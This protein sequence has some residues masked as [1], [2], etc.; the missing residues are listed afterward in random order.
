MDKGSV[1]RPQ[2]RQAC[3]GMSRLARGRSC[4]SPKMR[5]AYVASYQGPTLLDRRPIIR[6][7]SMSNRIKIELIAGLLHDGSKD[8]EIISQGEVIESSCTFYPSFSEPECFHPQIPVYYG[9]SLPIR[10]LNG[11]WSNRSTLH[12]LKE[13]HRANPFDL[14]IIFRSCIASIYRSHCRRPMASV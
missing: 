3:R 10:R 11:W 4:E 2:T 6:N 7:R 1:L 9:S 8:V 13:R 5:V 12:I 14:V